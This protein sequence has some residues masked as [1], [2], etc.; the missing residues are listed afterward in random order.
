VQVR[1]PR[2]RARFVRRLTPSRPAQLRS[3]DSSSILPSQT[4]REE[5][6][7]GRRVHDD[8]LV[9]RCPQSGIAQTEVVEEAGRHVVVCGEAVLRTRC[10]QASLPLLAAL[11][12][13]RVCHRGKFDN[14]KLEA[15]ASE[16]GAMVDFL[17][18]GFVAGEWGE[19]PGDDRPTG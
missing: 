3:T 11:G 15:P 14:L 2:G 12:P 16:S 6:P 13:F 8:E 1:P 4:S 19:V 17:A 9:G 10:L 5:G 18:P 7:H